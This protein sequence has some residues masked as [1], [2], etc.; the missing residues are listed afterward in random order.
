MPKTKA[1]S[2]GLETA[3]REEGGVMCEEVKEGIKELQGDRRRK[4]RKREREKRILTAA[5]SGEGGGSRL[6][7]WN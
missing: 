1:L 3:E 6:G 2:P 4:G 7:M 5:S